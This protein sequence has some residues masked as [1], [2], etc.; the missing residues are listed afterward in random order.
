MNPRLEAATVVDDSARSRVGGNRWLSTKLVVATLMSG[1]WW[2][3]S[4]IIF[5]AVSRS[6][7]LAVAVGYPYFIF[8]YYIHVVGE[9]SE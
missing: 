1:R 6:S 4:R 3:H 5:L 9:F 8:M 2:S 7:K